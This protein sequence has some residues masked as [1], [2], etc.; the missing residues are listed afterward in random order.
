MSGFSVKAGLGLVAAAVGLLASACPALAEEQ[1]QF[2]RVSLPPV[3]EMSESQRHIY[4]QSVAFFGDAVGPRLVLLETPEIGLAWSD[5]LS[6][7]ERSEL[8]R[9]LWELSIL[10]VARKW[11]SQFEWYAHADKAI[12]QGVPAGAVEQLRL[13][14][15]PELADDLQRA[16]YAYVAELHRDGRLSDQTYNGLRDLIGQKQLIELTALI[17]HYSM[18]AITLNAH[19]VRLPAGVEAPMGAV[20]TGSCEVSATT[21]GVTKQYSEQSKAQPQIHWGER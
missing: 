20:S 9:D 2:S 18:V 3:E 1:Q 15:A 4:D 12:A 6:A 8:R 13:G 11:T 17:G 5:L 14:C 19:E 10:V 21:A 7:I 16:T